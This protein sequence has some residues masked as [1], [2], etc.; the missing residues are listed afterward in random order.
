MLNVVF[1]WHM[2]QPYYVN[3]LTKTAMMPWVRLHAVKGYLDM[4]DVARRYP[5]LRLNFNFTPVL[6][7]Q[8]LELAEKR[9]EDL[10]ETWSR[11]SPETL[12]NDEKARI[13][14]NFFKINWTNLIM[15]FPRYKQLLEIRGRDYDLSSIKESVL[16]FT[17]QDYRDLQTWYNLAWC[18][19][20]A[21]KRFPELVE[22]KKKGA[23]F[24]EQEKN[25]VLDIHQEILRL[26]LGLYRDAQEQA[27]LTS[28][29]FFH[30]I[31]PLVYDTDF[32]LRAMPGRMLPPRFR[33]PEDV[34]AQLRLAQEQHR[35]VF[36]KAARGLWPSE[37]SVCP[38]VLPLIKEA[39]FEYFC[40]DEGILFH[41][42][43]KQ[44]DH[45]ELFQAWQCEHGGASLK[46]LFR[47]RPL[48]DYVGFT[49]AR[50][51]AEEASEHLLHH[52]EHIE[53]VVKHPNGAV[54]LALDG[55]NAWEAFADGGEAFLCQLYEKLL[56]SP[57]LRTRRMGDYMDEVERP[58]RIAKLHSGSW[59]ASNFDIWIG[60]PEENKAWEWVG[61][62]RD[63]LRA[64][65][66]A[67]QWPQEIADK[68]WR[69][70][71]AAEGSDWFWWYG[72]DF[73]TD[74]DFLFDELFRTHLQNVYRLFD[75]PPP[76][77]LDVP[78]CLQDIGGLT[79]KPL[80]YIEPQ[81]GEEGYYNWLGAGVYD[82]S[83]Q[84]TAMFQADRIGSKIFYGFNAAT[85]FF[86]LDVTR[87]PEKVIL[88]FYQPAAMRLVVDIAG[89]QAHLEKSADSVLF[90]PVPARVQFYAKDRLELAVPLQDLD[91]KEGET[92]DFVA[93]IFEQGVEKER[94][95]ERGLI[96]FRV[97]SS[98]F[99]MEHW[100]V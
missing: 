98:Q 73:Q 3:T 83:R 67:Q 89:Q 41:S 63:F 17:D 33:A 65:L 45:L 18:G 70:I 30:P 52:L 25:R 55:E 56:S 64:Q 40:T 51:S 27:E 1:L 31:M 26:V 96:E 85:F 97:P 58:S 39:G 44:A 60:D 92:V 91:W 8:I 47:E 23:N 28:T 42:L 71:Y 72:P 81:L 77:Y 87:L 100:F 76:E 93:Q 24:T 90:K 79:L 49:A 66:A 2:H 99:K 12:T 14:E 11:K 9:V 95:P 82:I 32:A 50:H 37:G 35:A 20:S 22:L 29:P 88:H 4:I 34:Q 86:R 43:D 53:S 21:E 74:A 38:E 48:S 54:C 13:L 75:C 16:H 7:A 10:W 84:Q 46:T 57:R 78:I 15:P 94:H 6:V 80:D 59:V 5:E 36:G 62:T 61:K 68:A 19:F 69:E